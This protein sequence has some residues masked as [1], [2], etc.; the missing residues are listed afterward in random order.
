MELRTEG[1]GEGGGSRKAFDFPSSAFK[2]LQTS[3][4]QP[5][6]A[7]LHTHLCI[8]TLPCTRRQTGAAAAHLSVSKW[9]IYLTTHTWFKWHTC[10]QDAN[11][12]TL[13]HRYAFRSLYHMCRIALIYSPEIWEFNWYR[14]QIAGFDRHDGVSKTVSYLEAGGF[15]GQTY[16]TT[17]PASPTSGLRVSLSS[18][19]IL[20]SILNVPTF[21][22]E[23]FCLA[24]YGAWQYT[25]TIIR[26]L[27]WYSEAL[28]QF[29]FVPQ[30]ALLQYIAS[31][32]NSKS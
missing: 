21:C 16:C 28:T 26:L 5:W 2:C 1:W 20:V 30:G 19:R 8:I 31:E 23:S 10:T 32:H 11:W 3:P 13:T 17:E 25:E 6:Q 29:C 24:E 7:H 27:F 14:A 9:H 12:G 15:F 18:R 4:S 22:L